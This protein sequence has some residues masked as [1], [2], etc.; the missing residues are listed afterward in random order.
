MMLHDGRSPNWRS[1]A[2][3]TRAKAMYSVSGRISRCLGCPIVCA[4]SWGSQ[5]FWQGGLGQCPHP[6][7]KFLPNTLY[8]GLSARWEG[9]I[10]SVSER[11]LQMFWL[12]NFKCN[13]LRQLAFMAGR[14][15]AVPPP[16]MQIFARYTASN[17]DWA[18]VGCAR[19][20]QL[21]TRCSTLFY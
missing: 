3:F 15:W 20:C 16:P 8:P 18:V 11:N 4:Q 2:Q 13:E 21:H 19:E 12:P 6:Q 7:C 5:H 1:C 10:Y 14:F 9:G 17:F